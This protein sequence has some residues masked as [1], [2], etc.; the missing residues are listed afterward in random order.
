[1]FDGSTS[2]HAHPA[3]GF[4]P[5]LTLRL[6]A[7]TYWQLVHTLRLA[8]PPPLSDAPEDRLRR[9]HAAIARVAALAPANAAEADLAAQSVAASEHSKAC[10]HLAQ[11][12]DTT[13][14]QAAKCR[15]QAIALMRLAQGALRLL[16]RLQQARAKREAAGAEGAAWMEHC[17]LG[18]MSEALSQPPPAAEPEVVARTA[19]PAQAAPPSPEPR[20]TAT[21][22]P[23][24]ADDLIAAAER[25]AAAYPE[26]A[27]TIRR[28]KR[29]PCDVRYFSPPES[30]LAAALMRGQTPVLAALDN[31]PAPF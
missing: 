15:A 26:R 8:L 28:T 24:L 13:A 12:P 4:D 7:D 29:L 3:P 19:P 20:E 1:M 31:V 30:A 10:L 14:D 21:A 2:D 11:L 18:L 23:P 5:G 22:A 27:A 16:L 6:P 17:A 9:D 25:Y